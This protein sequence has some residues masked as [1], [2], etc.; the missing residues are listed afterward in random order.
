M[1]STLRNET[2]LHCESG[3]LQEYHLDYVL[4]CLR[5]VNRF[6]YHPL[7]RHPAKLWTW[8][9]S[10]LCA[11]EE[12]GTRGAL[13]MLIQREQRS[14]KCHTHKYACVNKRK[15]TSVIALCISNYCVRSLAHNIN[16]TTQLNCI[17]SEG[18]LV[19]GN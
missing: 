8:K 5:C 14:D 12:K 17:H 6:I 1:N 10:P 4:L 16:N 3:R 18:S 9:L 2:M 13:K 19:L 7:T 15:Q 11:E